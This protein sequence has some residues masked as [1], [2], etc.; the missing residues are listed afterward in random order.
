MRE[1]VQK[2]QEVAQTKM[3]NHQKRLLLYSFLAS[4]TVFIGVWLGLSTLAMNAKVAKIE[5]EKVASDKEFAVLI[6]KLR[7]E[8]LE[9][10][11][12]QN[13]SVR[14]ET[15]E[16][17][18]AGYT[19][20]LKLSNNQCNFLN[21]HDNPTRIDV[22]VNKRHCVKPLDFEPKLA[23]VE[24]VDVATSAVDDYKALLSA[25]RKV[26]YN[27]TGTSG[28][29]SYADQAATYN[30][31]FTAEGQAEANLHSAL[32]GYSEHQTGLAIDFQ[33]DGCALDCFGR[34]EAYTWLKKNAHK[35]GY[36]ER[37]T[38]NET[39]V[40]GYGYEPWHWRYV[41]IETATDLKNSRQHNSRRV[42]ES[43]LE[44]DSGWHEVA[45]NRHYDENCVPNLAIGLEMFKF[46]HDDEACE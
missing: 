4:T 45:H 42:L 38:Q 36:I 21:D 6:K 3:R 13:E 33:I 24:G 28:Y 12:I 27:I 44:N 11:R 25:I 5:Q 34:T 40:T 35:Y 22:M 39:K 15:L 7:A 18:L 23:I 17:T 16:R 14:A 32:P 29:R 26:G 9:R 1:S 30:Y 10:E 8:R 43:S 41:G 31:W 19:E 2:K 46:A 37:Y 20:P